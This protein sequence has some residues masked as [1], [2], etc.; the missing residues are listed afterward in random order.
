[1]R[2]RTSVP[3]AR[4]SAA[5]LGCG[6]M[7]ASRG[8]GSSGRSG[9]RDACYIGYLSLISHDCNCCHSY[10]AALCLEHEEDWLLRKANKPRQKG[11][12]DIIYLP[13]AWKGGMNLFKYFCLTLRIFFAVL[14]PSF[15]ALRDADA[16]G[17]WPKVSCDASGCERDLYK[18]QVI[19]IETPA[20]NGTGVIIG[21]RGNDYT[22]LTSEHVIPYGSFLSEYNIYSPTKNKRYRLSSVEWPAGKK[23]DIAVGTF[24]VQ[25][26]DSFNISLIPSLNCKQYDQSILSVWCV[27]RP[28]GRM[29]G[30]SLPS[31][32]VIV[33]VLRYNE[34]IL[35][36]RVIGNQD[37][38]EFMYSA[39]T[40]PGMSGG[41]IFGDIEI[42]CAG[43]DYT[44]GYFGLLAIHGRS[45][46]YESN[47]A[48][49]GR[50][51][52]SLAVPV[53]LIRTYLNKNASRFGI[54]TKREE[55]RN[56]AE[57]QYCNYDAN[58]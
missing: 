1:M 4:P 21:R 48:V 46:G 5:G 12:L 24:K 33:P 30:Y 51:G 11:L 37:G 52:I 57:A 53:D 27:S 43:L 50:S 17:A 25:E 47:G 35:Q 44:K 18:R 39:N 34:I 42:V 45:E 6:G 14:A 55:I 19:I 23:Y 56:I 41:P 13:Q 32:S 8:R 26:G 15:L 9:S 3:K 36:E 20:S 58:L 49:I 22:F 7:G 29:T 16:K 2:V 40:Y 10:G 28:D 38:F 54:A 31:T